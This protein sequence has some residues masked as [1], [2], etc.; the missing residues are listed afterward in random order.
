[1]V[2]LWFM[3]ATLAPSIVSAHPA[4]SPMLPAKEIGLTPENTIT[5]DPQS[6]AVHT[7]NGDGSVT[8]SFGP[9]SD[10]DTDDMDF[11]AN[12]AD[13]LIPDSILNVMAENILRGIDEDLRSR[14]DW[15]DT[16]NR[17]IDLLGLKLEDPSSDVSTT[18]NISK[19]HHPLLIEAVVRYQANANAELLPAAG[20][21]K[22]RDDDPDGSDPERTRMAEAFE[23]DFNHYLTVD[24]KEYYPD[25]SRMFF[26]QGFCGNGF[27]KVYRCPLRKA[28]VSDY[29]SAPDLIV[30]NDVTS[31]SNAARIT[32]RTYMRQAVMVRMQLSGHYR[33][34]EMS[35][36][37]QEVT[38]VDKKIGGVEGIDKQ[39]TLPDNYL[40]C[41]YETYTEYDV[42]GLE[43][44]DGDGDKTGLPLPYRVSIEKSSRKILEVR[45][46]WKED[47]QDYMPRTRFVHYGYVPGLGFYHYGLVH[48]LGQTTRALTTIERLLIDA[49]MFANFPGVLLS[50]AGGKQETTQIRV[51]PG[52]STVIKCGGLPLGQVVMPLPYKEPGGALLN[53]AK[54]IEDDARRL[55]GTN[56]I[57]VG[58]GRADVPVG[59]TLAMIEQATKMEGAV[60]KQNHRAQQEEFLLLKELFEED[61]ESLTKFNKKPAYKWQTAEEIADHDLVPASDPNTPSHIHR[62]MKATGLAQTAQMAPQ[63]YN[64]YAVHTTLL[65]TLGYNPKALLLPP[66]SGQQGPQIDP[67]KMAKVQT[68]QKKVEAHLQETAM[69]TKAKSDQTA[70]E[71]QDR[72]AER[73]SREN[74]QKMKTMGAMAQ[75]KEQEQ[76]DEA[77][78]AR[79]LR[80][81]S[82]GRHQD[83]QH[84]M[85]EQQLGHQH[86]MDQQ[87]SQQQHEKAVA[88]SKDNMVSSPDE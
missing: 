88:E 54:E 40:H 49:G 24:R 41:V 53:I 58:E 51:P 11:D 26:G 72:A 86:D 7:E 42:P 38:E 5:I 46:N 85:Q 66:G 4:S 73:Q 39:I 71:M 83:H 87:F 75:Q 15:E 64:M 32:H 16:F 61:P 22:V 9:E 52:G 44:K 80:A 12:L 3:T 13:G 36:P 43:H 50:D 28:P 81:E 59:T 1:M 55:G 25:T 70:A 33:W 62:V 23:R 37:N 84:A 82:F 29:V 20:P 47:D 2:I 10:I 8:I 18:G 45:R 74:V 56:E 63:L 57:N 60:H 31:L 69:N 68:D 17:G 21:V 35:T 65:T 79:G 14:R 19:V 30:S 6:G 67:A 78:E 76:H 77:K 48:L 34:V 27:K